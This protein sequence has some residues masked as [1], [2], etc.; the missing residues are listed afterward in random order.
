MQKVKLNRRNFVLSTAATGAVLATA[1]PAF[2]TLAND[3]INLGVIGCGGRGGEHMAAFSKLSGVK[4]SG[5][6]DPDA[7]RAADAQKLFPTA[8]TYSDLRELLDDKSI[9]AVVIAACNHW[10]CL[11]AIWAMQA[12]KDVYVE[13]PLSHSQ[14]EGEQT[15]AA[16]RKYKRIC[17]VGTQQRSDPMQAEIKQ[18]LHDEQA[19]GKLLTA[20]V[21]RYGVRKTIGKR[22]TPLEI[23]PQVA[24]DLWLGPAQDRPIY[25]EKLQYDWHWDWNTGS[26]EMGN[27]GVHVLDDLRNNVFQDKV[28]LPKRIFG[29]GGRVAWNDAGETPNVHFVYFDTGSIPVVIGLSNLPAAPGGNKPPSRPGPESG[30]VVYC[31]GGRLEGQRGRAA[32][33][34]KDGKE[35]RKFKGDTGKTHQQNFIECMREGN[36]EK[37]N[38]DVLIGHHST[39]WCNLAN[40]A[41]QSGSAYSE[42]AA[43]QIGDEIWTG[44]LGE[45]RD[46]LQAHGIKMNDS[47]IKLSPVLQIDVKSERFVGAHAEAANQLLKREYRAPFVVPTIEA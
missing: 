44:L 4:I 40:I 47:Q 35:M 30:Y 27:W 43:K 10:H 23:D 21:N 28:T 37:L 42:E 24:Y 36:P 1:R 25:R 18:F 3:E 11:A 19:L 33:F 13:K 45:M 29:G 20:R 7:K 2:A 9:N 26:G 46:H 6:C 38:A 31:E 22:A 8:K 32:A 16:A 39:G 14:W 34:D 15:V 17:Q 5:L 41:Y 12:G